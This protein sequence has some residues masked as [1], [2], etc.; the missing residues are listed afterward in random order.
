MCPP[1]KMF[2]KNGKVL[3]FLTFFVWKCLGNLAFVSATCVGRV[4]EGETQG[5]KEVEW[6]WH[7]QGDGET[8]ITGLGSGRGYTGRDVGALKIVNNRR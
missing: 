4:G 7:W 5:G 8:G 1:A 3:S 6:Q 2:D